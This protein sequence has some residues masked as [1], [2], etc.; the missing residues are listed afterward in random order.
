[1]KAL[2]GDAHIGEVTLAVANLDRSLAFYTDV[3]GLVILWQDS[4][5]AALGAAEGRP[6]LV[7]L[8][9]QVGAVARPRGSSGLYHIAIRVPSRAALGRS[10]RRLAERRW[11]LTGASDHLVSEALYLDDPDG[12]GLEVYRD[13]PREHWRV[14]DGEVEMAT[15]PLDLDS[16]AA[17]RGAGGAWS[18]VEPETNIGHVHLHVPDLGS[19]EALYCGALGFTPTLRRY[20]GALF[21]AAGGYHHHVGLNVWAGPGAPPPPPAAVGLRAFTVEAKTLDSR[22]VVDAATEV[23]ITVR[24]VA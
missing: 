14:S 8:Q 3:V 5:V 6:S 7:R 15:E 19:A 18:G 17:E 10:L 1:M 2:P 20:P 16:V 21:V 23:A 4:G 13:R 24:P 9:E 12:L 11:P 22:T